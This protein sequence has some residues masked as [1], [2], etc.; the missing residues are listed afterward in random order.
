M[1]N[2][3]AANILVI[4]I[5]ALGDVLRTTPALS[6]LRGGVTW[7]TSEAAAPLLAGNP[8]IERLYCNGHYPDSL[9]DEEFDLVVNL[10]DDVSAATLASKIKTKR[11]IGAYLREGNLVYTESASEWF[12]MS[13]I[14]RF[15]KKRADEVKM[16]NRRTY[17][18]FL[19]SM[20]GDRFEGEEY[21][22]TMPLKTIPTPNLVGL[23]IRT[24]EVWP[25]KRWN[26]FEAL[27]HRLTKAGFKLKTFQQ[28]DRLEEYVDDINECEYIVCGDTLAMHLGLA[29]RKR[30][31][32][33][34]TCTSPHEIDDYGR[35]IKV[36]SP[37]WKEYFYRRDFDPAPA[38][39]ISVESVFE[40]VMAIADL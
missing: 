32:A 23:E 24:G 35:M 26:K 16:N 5:G 27:A 12:D 37:L 2:E 18:E 20:L 17:Q 11:L 3:L 30:V 4:K 29:L 34:F 14:S 9:L 38:E 31:V 7:V 25:M 39:A 15:G 22:L 40:A 1:R 8:L 36:I 10:E 33:I 13:L 19:F 6:V 28:R 21:L